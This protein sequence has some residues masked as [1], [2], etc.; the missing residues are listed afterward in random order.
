MKSSVKYPNAYG[1][2]PV[3][4]RNE[5][6]GSYIS[7]I[8]EKSSDRLL[9]VYCSILLCSFMAYDATD[10]MSYYLKYRYKLIVHIFSVDK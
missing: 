1:Y 10:V 5:H 9:L 4:S 7:I 6:S 3:V 8:K 2:I